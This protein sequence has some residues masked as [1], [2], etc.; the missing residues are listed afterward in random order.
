ME[1][2]EKYRTY[3]FYFIYTFSRHYY[4]MCQFFFISC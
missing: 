3:G 2:C 1:T 4:T